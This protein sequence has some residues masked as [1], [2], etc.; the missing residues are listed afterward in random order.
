MSITE[1][2]NKIRTAVLGKEVRTAIADSIEECYKDATTKDN[3]NME[4][5]YARGEYNSLSDRLN[6]QDRILNNSA[7]K[8]ELE[9]EKARID[10][11]TKL[12][13]GSTTGDAELIDIRTKADG[14]SANSAGSA[15]R[16]QFTNVNSKVNELRELA[17]SNN[18][19]NTIVEDGNISTT[20]GT[21]V[22]NKT[23]KYARTKE[24][25]EVNK[26]GYYAF[27]YNKDDDC[28][29]SAAYIFA[30][31]ADKTFVERLTNKNIFT[32]DN[33]M[34][35]NVTVNSEVK[36]LK[37]LFK[38]AT[39]K[40]ETDYISYINSMN[41]QL[42]FGIT[43]TKYHP[44][45]IN[46][47]SD[48]KIENLENKLNSIVDITKN[49]KNF[50]DGSFEKGAIN[51][52]NGT[53]TVSDT[54]IRTNF[55][56]TNNNSY[57]TLSIYNVKKSILPINSVRIAEYDA[58]KNFISILSTSYVSSETDKAV[59]TVQTSDT[60]KYL[61]LCCEVSSSST[62]DEAIT[63]LNEAKIQLEY[64]QEAT[65]YE[66]CK[67]IVKK[68]N[69][70]SLDDLEK[71][72]DTLSM[73][74][75]TDSDPLKVIKETP[76]YTR[77]FN[78]IGCIGDS[79]TKGYVGTSTVSKDFVDYSFPSYLEKICGNKVYNWGV[80]GATTGMW[81]E[82]YKGS[83]AHIECFDGNHKCDAY[84]IGLGGN[85]GIKGKVLG[86]LDD[87]KADYNDNPDTFYG[88]MDKIIRKVKEVQPKAKI[89]LT[90]YLIFNSTVVP[91]FEEAIRELSTKYENCYLLDL[92]LYGERHCNEFDYS[93][94]VH[95]NAIGYLKKA[96]MIATYI[97]WVVR[98]NKAD[99][100]NVQFIG[101]D[102]E[103]K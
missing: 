75:N 100:M 49:T 24:F 79:V 32:N 41:I 51:L 90:T 84:I 87:I 83:T 4:V 8:T 27:Q 60:A 33:K 23:T 55:I 63:F 18:I 102:Y 19:Y 52:A 47:K 21:L 69:V 76:G 56:A 38:I 6:N 57:V 71:S 85:D 53:K 29:V 9:V 74:N 42:E 92:H 73:N 67:K 101:T 40:A 3:A 20:D 28:V 86:S 7:T 50:Y 26:S 99:F 103:I 1:N 68:E 11:F 65:D 31:R 93:D 62:Q 58:D 45:S 97:D 44:H 25:I 61:L 13:E 82:G 91:P 15:V 80:S 89:F 37:I 78:S 39:D 16:E 35:A 77:I 14:T 64:S 98:D 94:S 96:H 81:L 12:A 30:Y 10:N 46:L 17:E 66:E 48:D 5:S 70:E 54:F 22:D 36:Y 95:Q 43:A 2:I 88:N 34:Y 59:V 72:I